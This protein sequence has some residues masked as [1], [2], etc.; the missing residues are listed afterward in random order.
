[1]IRT[2]SDIRI[3]VTDAVRDPVGDVKHVV[4]E[5]VREDAWIHPERNPLERR[6]LDQQERLASG[7]VRGVGA[8]FLR[9]EVRRELGLDEDL[10]AALGDQLVEGS[11]D[12][13][14]ASEVVLERVVG[15][16][17]EERLEVARDR[18]AIHIAYARRVVRRRREC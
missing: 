18:D 12:L 13:L 8:E 4:A 15:A 9:A 14:C 7:D 16:E 2:P 5:L 17:G 3:G 1:V 11:E 10:E 6:H